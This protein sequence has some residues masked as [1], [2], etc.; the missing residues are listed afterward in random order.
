MI[1]TS[2]KSSNIPKL[3]TLEE[4][5][6][7]SQRFELKKYRLKWWD[8]WALGITVVIGGVATTSHGMLVYWLLVYA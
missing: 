1:D 8:I 6:N 2:D 4:L 5:N 3:G 7:E